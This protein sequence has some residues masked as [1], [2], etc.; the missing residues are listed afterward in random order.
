[1]KRLTAA[2]RLSLAVAAQLALAFGLLVP[3]TVDRLNGQEITLETRLADP[4][5]VLRGQYMTLEYPISRVAA[6]PD[7]KAPGVAYV[8]LVERAG[9]WTGDRATSRRP[10][11]GIFLRG[12]VQAVVDGQALLTYGLERFYLSETAAQEQVQASGELRARVLVGASGRS[13]LLGLSRGGVA[14]R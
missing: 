14:I 12:R 6:D 7:V 1:M 4:R 2:R 11:S 13:R 3:G 10:T 9:L 8:P 5:D